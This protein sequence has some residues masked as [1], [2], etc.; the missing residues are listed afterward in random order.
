MFDCC[1]PEGEQL[2]LLR[3]SGRLRYL[4]QLPF[5]V[6]TCYNLIKIKK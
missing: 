1:S 3:G 5:V 6:H 2:I 4:W